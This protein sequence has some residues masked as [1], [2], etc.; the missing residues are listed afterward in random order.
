MRWQKLSEKIWQ[1]E[2]N[3][4]RLTKDLFGLSR[5]HIYHMQSDDGFIISIIVI[6]MSK[7]TRETTRTVNKTEGEG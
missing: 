7:N 6:T 3:E 1:E 5:W 4:L 2:G